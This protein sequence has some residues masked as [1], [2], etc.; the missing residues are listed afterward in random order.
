[1]QDLEELSKS[2]NNAEV[3]KAIHSSAFI[4]SLEDAKPSDPV[5]HSRALW[6]GDFVAGVPVGLR[7]RWVDK[8]VQFVVFDNAY[9]G[10]MGEHSVMDGTPTARM[11]DEILDWLEDPSFDHGA[12]LTTTKDVPVPLDWDVTLATTEAIA[13]ADVAAREL[14]ESQDLGF[15]LTSY[16]KDAIKKFGVSP[17]SWAQMIVQLAYR[18]LLN[19]QKRNGGTYEAATTR[20]FFKGRTEAIRV[21]SEESDAW[22]VSMDDPTVSPAQRKAL[23]DAATKRHITLAKAAG[24]GQGVDRHLFGTPPLSN[25][26]PQVVSTSSRCRRFEEGSSGR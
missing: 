16:G 17:D 18:R 25:P 1:L 8:P 5:H 11:C 23:F 4:I 10:L 3:I 14:C 19:G 22:V 15:Y 2:P 13:K 21:V 20:R 12:P 6:H 26:N 7:N 24:Q 9:A